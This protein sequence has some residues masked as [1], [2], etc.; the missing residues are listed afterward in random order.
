MYGSDF[1]SEDDNSVIPLSRLGEIHWI[2][3]YR[4]NDEFFSVGLDKTNRYVLTPGKKSKDI[5][6]YNITQIDSF[7]PTDDVLN[8]I[9]VESQLSFIFNALKIGN[10][11]FTSYD[12]RNDFYKFVLMYLPRKL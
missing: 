11:I 3:G 10:L 6:F 1:L 8:I 7:T 2:I 12:L 4:M 5:F 9:D